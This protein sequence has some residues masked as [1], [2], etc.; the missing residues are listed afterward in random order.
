MKKLLIFLMIAIPLVV[1]LVVNLTVTA[2]TGMVTIPVDSVVLDKTQIEG[3]VDDSITLK[4]TVYPRNAS[5]QDIIWTSSNEEVARVDLNGNVSF[6]GYGK[7]CI[8]A[9]TVDGNKKATCFY[10]ITDTEVHQINFLTDN[11]ENGN[12]YVG[13]GENLQLGTVAYPAEATNKNI[14]YTSEDE[15]IATID[16]NGLVHGNKEGRVKI[17]AISEQHPEIT[18]S[19]IVE[20]VKPLERVILSTEEAVTS[21]STYQISY[22][23]YPLDASVSSVLYKSSDEEIATVSSSGLVTFKKAGEIFVTLTSMQGKIEEKIKIKYTNGYASK[24]ILDSYIISESINDGGCNIMYKTIPESVDV[25]VEF[26]SDDENIAYVDDSGYVQYIA[27]GTTTIRARI[28]SS[29]NDYIE[30]TVSVTIMSP[31]TAIVIEDEIIVGTSNYQLQPKSYPETS[32][33]E[34]YYYHSCDE[35]VATVSKDGAV[36]FL[37]E[38]YTSVDIDIYANEDLSL[39]HKRVRVTYTKGC[40]IEIN[41]ATTELQINYGETKQ[42]EYDVL[43]SDL[44]NANIEFKVISQIVNG[45]NEAVVNVLSDGEIIALGGGKAVIEISTT[46]YSGV[47]LSKLCEVEVVRKVEEIGFVT[48]IDYYNEEYV[49]CLQEVNFNLSSLTTDA[50]NKNINWKLENNIAIKKN[51]NTILFN[52]TGVAEL[53]LYSEDG[54]AIRNIKIRYMKDNLIS[55]EIKEVPTSVNVGESYVFEIVSTLPSNAVI[56]PYI[57]VGNQIT[58]S[59]LEKVFEVD[60]KN[61]LSAIAGGTGIITLIVSNLQFTYEI[62]GIKK[63]ESLIVSPANITTT[64]SKIILQ[65]Q[66]LPE[67]TTNKNVEYI[68]DDENVASISN[69]VLTFHKNGIVYITAKTTDGSNIANNFTIEKTEKGSGTVIISGDSIKMQVGESNNID[70]STIDFE[71]V[72]AEFIIQSQTPIIENREVIS[73]N[74][75]NVKAL[76]L[77]SAVVEC[78]L[79][80]SFGEEKTISIEINVIQISEDAELDSDL[81]LISEEYVTAE[82]EVEL[83]FNLLPV[84]TENKNYTVSFIKFTSTVDEPSNPYIVD[85]KLFFLV[86]GTATVKVVSEDGGV[87]KQFRI[88]YTGGDAISATLNIDSK[89]TLAVGESVEI[90][91][92]KWIPNNTQNTQ[93]YIKENT[94]TQGVAEVASINGNVITGV[95]GGYSKLI[96]ELSNGIVKEV[97]VNVLTK[98]ESIVI[99]E[100]YL[101]SEKEITLSATVLPSNA[102]SKA[103]MYSLES[104]EIA[105]IEGSKITFT[106]PGTVY[107]NITATDGSKV[108]KQVK[109]TSTF[110]YMGSFELNKVSN[111]INKGNSFN[112]YVKNYLPKNAI[113]TE[114]YFEI[115]ENITNDGSD[116]QV[117]SVTNDGKVTGLYGGTVKIGV[118]TLDYYGEKIES[119]CEVKVIANAKDISISFERDLSIKQGIY[120]TGLSILNF[121]KNILPSDATNRNITCVSLDEN[122]AVVYGDKITFLKEGKVTLRF[123]NDSGIEGY[124]YK[125]H[126]FYYTNGVLLSCELDTTDFTN[127]V[128]DLNAEDK[129]TLKLINCIPMDV[130]VVNISMSNLNETRVAPKYKVISFSDNTIN[131]LN[132]GEVSFTLTVGSKEL[133]RYTVRVERPIS[134]IATETTVYTNSKQ[135]QIIASALPIDTQQTGLTYAV[136]GGE[137]SVDENG[138]VTITTGNYITIEITSTANSTIKKSVCIEYSNKVKKIRFNETLT[139]LA[140]DGSIELK[141]IGEPL[142]VEDF[143]VIFVSSNESVAK[144]VKTDTY[145]A[146]VIGQSQGEVIITAYVNGDTEICVSRTFTVIQYVTEI[147]FTLNTI[148]NE[149]GIGGYRVWGNK[150]IGEEIVKKEDNQEEKKEKLIQT[151]QMEIFTIKPS[152]VELA[153]TTSNEE[154]ATVNETGLVTFIGTGKVTITAAPL[155]QRDSSHPIKASYTFTVVEGVNVYTFAQF[156][157]YATV[158]K[159]EK[160]DAPG[161]AIVVQA[162]LTMTDKEAGT[163]YLR[164]NL[165]GNGYLV[166]L[167]AQKDGGRR[168]ATNAEILIDNANLR[169]CSFADQA[170]L[171]TLGGTGVLLEIEYSDKIGKGVKVKNSILENCEKVVL[172]IDSPATF[173]GCIIRNSLVADIMVRRA[174]YNKKPAVLNVDNSILGKALLTCILFEPEDEE[175][176]KSDSSQYSIVNINENVTFYNWIKQSDFNG[177][178]IKNAI[179]D[180]ISGIFGDLA[181]SVIDKM[182]AKEFNDILET[183]PQYVYNYKNE[184]YIMMGVTSLTG[185]EKDCNSKANF[186]KES[187]R[188]FERKIEGYIDNSLNISLPYTMKVV[189]STSETAKKAG[190]TPETSCNS[191]DLYKKIK[192]GF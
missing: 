163:T 12:Y 114:V 123:Q 160:D 146:K 85:N 122:I 59:S 27:G 37:K 88:K 150:F 191:T 42:I 135:Y 65:S 5:N 60:G 73:I 54:N 24:L 141:V 189:T 108:S 82:S 138:L 30:E 81:D 112:L 53:K 84:E 104:C 107:V 14:L 117:A 173:T 43:P 63:A 139:Q 46:N 157:K 116:N 18:A 22:S 29:E 76:N 151:F 166:D 55:A 130:S 16:T 72:T 15:S 103:L 181:S 145:K 154:I 87:S 80:N 66:V 74:G 176:K 20:V 50:T 132:G 8:I 167:S 7:G 185:L 19:I 67:D 9:T 115:I 190:I 26:S 134:D 90:M 39:V 64:N 48:D 96:I 61:K 156:K 97:T 94:H 143:E 183:D 159:G 119:I 110:G 92:S 35:N 41:V 126:D 118:Y 23:V 62:A 184:K 128:L 179:K 21:A 79:T 4:A 1:I 182:I 38:E 168:L 89:I 45:D 95:A 52:N 109:I 174:D 170:A 13:V 69:G 144:V 124:I 147:E 164:H 77:G 188:H 120:Y 140:F 56:D 36:K 86:Q 51:N 113:N 102:T 17:T 68:V 47:K 34:N 125:D 25:D 171:S 31:A 105:K 137:G 75:N 10:Y 152:M 93:I 83:K 78:L 2:V 175:N 44:Q 3:I 28:K 11:T 136:V 192:R 178:F 172:L 6:I 169:G 32:T 165:Y 58:Q 131:C 101:I 33:N 49:T 57:K 40:P 91:V 180:Y 129:Y 153:W 133:G 158:K 149:P 98:V 121:S 186:E 177:D 162:E 148:D 100:N 70:L 142:N 161:Y 155:I 99:E 106:K 111:S 127:G 187:G 71:Y